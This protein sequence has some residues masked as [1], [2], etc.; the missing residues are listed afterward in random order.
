MARLLRKVSGEDRAARVGRDRARHCCA[1][2]ADESVDDD[3]DTMRRR[4]QNHAGDGGNFQPTH[5]T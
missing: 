1:R 5:T 4:A 3:S 2:R